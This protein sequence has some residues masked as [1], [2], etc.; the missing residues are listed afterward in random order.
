MLK[1]A[2]YRELIKAHQVPDPAT[3]R[4]FEKLE[5]KNEYTWISYA[6]YGERVLNFAAGFDNFLP[7]RDAHEKVV[8]YA[9]TQIDWLVGGLGVMSKGCPIVTIY[10]TL[11]E[12]GAAHGIKQTK[13]K[14]NNLSYKS[15]PGKY[16]NFMQNLSIYSKINV[17]LIKFSS[18]DL[19][20]SLLSTGSAT[21]PTART[22]AYTL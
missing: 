2:G 13:A 3:G 5:L 17:N 19:F 8:V 9:D 7:K 1:A 20:D 6:E 21:A 14:T 10:A 18:P 11:G 16:S 22:A 15:G 4:T 12:D